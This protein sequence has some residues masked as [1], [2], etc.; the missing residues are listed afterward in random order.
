MLCLIGK[1]LLSLV[2]L[3]VA[4]P[5]NKMDIYSVC[6]CMC[7]CVHIFVALYMFVSV[8]VSLFFFSKHL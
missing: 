8:C 1:P 5:L 4:V 2:I 3:R 7:V 6:M